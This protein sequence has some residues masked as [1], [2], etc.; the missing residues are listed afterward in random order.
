[1]QQ[2]VAPRIEYYDI[3][4]ASTQVAL[5]AALLANALRM[6]YLLQMRRT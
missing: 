2:S 5:K 6:R 1:M 3:L 4:S